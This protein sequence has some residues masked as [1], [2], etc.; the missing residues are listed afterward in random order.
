MSTMH[1]AR[2]VAGGKYVVH[3]TLWDHG[4]DVPLVSV[5]AIRRVKMR[6]KKKKGC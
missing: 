4:G 2:I 6:K 1:V 5:S 3:L